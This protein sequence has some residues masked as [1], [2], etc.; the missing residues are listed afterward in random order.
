MKLL[1]TT[2]VAGLLVA[3]SAATALELVAMSH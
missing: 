2:A 1:K 3:S